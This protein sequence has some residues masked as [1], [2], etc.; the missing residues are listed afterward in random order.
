MI[1][2]GEVIRDGPD[3]SQ[4]GA[5]LPDGAADDPCAR[6]LDAV[7]LRRQEGDELKLRRW[8]EPR[9]RALRL[10]SLCAYA[11]LIASREPLGQQERER[12][13]GHFSTGETYFLR[14]RDL[15]ALLARRILPELVERRKTQRTLRLW[16]AGC[17]S[18]EE[19]YSLAML[20]DEMSGPLAGWDVRILGTDIS[21]EAIE[22]ARSGIYGQWSFRG[23]DAVRK[24]RYFR[25][26]AG[27]WQV[28]ERLRAMVEFARCDLL[29]DELPGLAG[30]RAGFDL[31]LC[32]NVFIYLS[33]Q[34]VARIVARLTGR[35]CEEGYLV[36][37]HGELIGCPTP[38]LQVC[39]Y[40]EATLYRKSRAGARAVPDGATTELHADATGRTSP[41]VSARPRMMAAVAPLSP[42]RPRADAAAA[43]HG[44]DALSSDPALL[45]EQAWRDA[46][47]GAVEAAR[48][49]CHR[50][51]AA[52]PLD[53]RPY[54]L[55]AQLAQEAGAI[56]EARGLLRK[57]L[58]LDPGNTAASLELAELHAQ[59]GDA[60]GALR[61]RERVLRELSKAPPQ[62]ASVAAK[63]GVAGR[64]V[65]TGEAS[66]G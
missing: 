5:A 49:A 27:G 37:G 61:M 7:G 51:L 53:P 63:P 59:A 10:P 32:R 24:A 43:S 4:E 22:G 55:L 56:E 40:P 35:L 50:M 1:R 2:H 11:Q 3:P 31:V 52:A 30:E 18:G 39:S 47:R 64:D 48:A 12:L 62:P 42:A 41:V 66:H 19:A 60:E 34:A 17:A 45:L 46:D 23:F 13:M 57:V 26:C 25:Q 36:P 54:Y 29:H 8:L 15:Y 38:A 58:Y 16:S 44:A 65:S 21:G 33:P 28:A 14:D 20:L 6:I 9:L